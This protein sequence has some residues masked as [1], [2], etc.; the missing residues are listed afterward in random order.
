MM[1]TS[2]QQDA[3]A[4]THRQIVTILIGL[5]LGM[6]LAA[7]DQTIVATAMRTIADDLSGFSIQAWATTAFL[8]T[9]TISTPLYGK[10][11]D[12]YGRKPFFLFAIGIFIVGSV[13]CGLAGS[14]YE[15]AAFRAVQG[16]GAGGL[17]SL[18]F[19]IIGD[20]VPPR[21][22]AKYQGYFLAVFG[23]SSVLGPV[24][25]GFFAGADE[26]LGIAGWRWIFY[27]NVPIAAVAMVVVT[28]V[29]HIP[30]RRQEHRIDWPGALALIV[31]LVPLLTVA[32][33]GR[34]WG[35]GSGRSLLCY[36]IG[37]V[38]L[39]AFLLAERAYGDEALL[40][41]RLFRGRTFAVGSVSSFVVGMA[42]LGGLLIV[43]LYLQ[44]VKGSTPTEGGLQ[45][46]PFVLGIMTSSII[47]GQVIYRTGR[48][49][50]FP[51]VGSALMVIALVLFSRITADTPLWLTMLVM[52]LMGLG[53]GGNMQPMITAVQN[54]A[55][56]REIGV[57]TS[58]VS[59]FRSMGG[60]L[61]A[62]VFL[63]LL[64]AYLPGK[65][66][67]AFAAASDTAPFRAALASHPDQAQALQG[68]AAGGTDALNDTSFINRLPEALAHPFKVG[69]ADSMSLVFLVSA[70]IMAVGLIA[71]AFLPELPLRQHS[72]AQARAQ[73]DAARDRAEVTTGGVPPSPR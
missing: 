68:A 33:Q 22:R 14:L 65:I 53:L 43:P 57:S 40:P 5:V 11:S 37:A 2:E 71:V 42:M 64:F 50:L 66:R 17:M 10:L 6:F 8:I 36:A 52:A 31:G 45:L 60:T 56:P 48:Y 12:I 70:A 47:S 62:A 30:H 51:I 7:L 19:A 13:L 69:F 25:G 35:W 4:L 59:F 44:I 9:S 54:A 28:R 16:I 73:E 61:G 23:T 34:E 41:L 1:Q 32:E 58:A 72:A 49:R 63:S 46:I 3:G 18:A 15:L 55:S 39:V 38:G 21:E 20:I 24:L 27:I 26:I 29:L 67:D